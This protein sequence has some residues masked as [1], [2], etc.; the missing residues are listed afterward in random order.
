MRISNTM[1]FDQL[2][3]KIYRQIVLEAG[4]ELPAMPEQGDDQGGGLDLPD[5]SEL[6]GDQE[7]GADGSQEAKPEEYELAKLAI[8]TLEVAAGLRLNPAVY[9]AFEQGKDIYGIVNYIERQVSHKSG[10]KEY[11]NPKFYEALGIRNLKGMNIG[12]KMKFFQNSSLPAEL[13]L[14]GQRRN[15]WIRIIINAARYGYRDFVIDF[16]EDKMNNLELESLYQQL[17]VDMSADT[18]GSDYDIPDKL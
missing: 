14:D 3:E 15:G 7:T 4:D 12:Q 5:L 6:E 1:K 2:Y 11:D 16:V 8:K 9:D 18:R 10:I 13:Q 17:A